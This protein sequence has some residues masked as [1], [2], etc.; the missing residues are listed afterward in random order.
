MNDIYENIKR[1]VLRQAKS[2]L[3]QEV[4][5][6]LGIKKFEL[7]E[8][9]KENCK[10]SQIGF[11]QPIDSQLLNTQ[12][13]QKVRSGSIVIISILIAFLLFLFFK[14]IIPS[15]SYLNGR[16]GITMIDGNTV[17]KE[18]HKVVKKSKINEI[19]EIP[20]S[21]SDLKVEDIKVSTP[22]PITQEIEEKSENNHIA[23]IEEERTKALAEAKKA[24]ASISTT[25]TSDTNSDIK[26]YRVRSGDS[27][28]VIAQRVY[29]S[30]SPGNIEKLKRMNN[31]RNPR[32][33]RAGQK[34]KV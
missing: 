7:N 13:A 30:A 22:K 33:L 8:K 26:E 34:L 20:V 16:E 23:K 18:I 9:I 4:Q 11:F 10:D 2:I 14:L 31:I 24:A 32:S 29:G 25:N 6:E 17:H 21:E 1:K 3:P 19:S 15:D 12:E 27:L 28:A 5:E